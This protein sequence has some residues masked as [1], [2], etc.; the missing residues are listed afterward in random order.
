MMRAMNE[1]AT[2]VRRPATYQDVLDAPENMVA[3]LIRG[4]LHLHPRPAP[5]HALAGSFLGGELHGPFKRGR[6]GPGGW[7]I[8][9]EPELHLGPDVLVP[10]LAG[11]R[12]E[13][14]P[15]LPETAWFELAPDWVCEV[16]SPGTRRLDLTEKRDVYARQLGAPL[17]LKAALVRDLGKERPG[18][19]AAHRELL[20]VDPGDVLDDPDIDIVRVANDPFLE[21]AQRFERHQR[22]Q[23]ALNRMPL[24]SFGKRWR[25]RRGA[26]LPKPLRLR[27]RLA[28]AKARAIE[29]DPRLVAE[30]AL[31]RHVRE[32]G[33]ENDALAERRLQ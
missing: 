29:A 33:F 16:L 8:L 31:L 11:W 5:P 19:P 7:V 25:R 6:G 30:P 27:I 3:E 12:R 22:H 13:R 2:P 1:H 14:M 10:D 20:T 23:P 32:A 9:F 26:I 4:G 15:T 28:S 17:N 21:A 18:L 24:I